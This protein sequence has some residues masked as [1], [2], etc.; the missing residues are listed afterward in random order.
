MASTKMREIKNEY[1]LDLK[2]SESELDS[3]L[4]IDPNAAKSEYDRMLLSQNSETIKS[5]APEIQ[6]YIARNIIKPLE[7]RLEMENLPAPEVKV[8]KIGPAF[9]FHSDE[10]KGTI[11][12]NPLAVLEWIKGTSYDKS[13][14]HEY[15]HFL[16]HLFNRESIA[17][18]VKIN[19]RFDKMYG[20]GLFLKDNLV[21]TEGFAE[22][23]AAKDDEKLM[24][25][26]S[27]AKGYADAKKVSEWEGIRFLRKAFDSPYALGSIIYDLAFRAGGVKEVKKLAFEGVRDYKEMK[28]LYTGYCEK[29]GLEPIVAPR[30]RTT[31]SNTYK[32]MV[33]YNATPK[34]ESLKAALHK[35]D[36][37]MRRQCEAGKDP[38]ILQFCDPSIISDI[39]AESYWNHGTIVSSFSMLDPEKV[40]QENMKGEGMSAVIEELSKG[41]WTIVIDSGEYN[42]QYMKDLC[43]EEG[44]AYFSIR[45]EIPTRL[46][47]KKK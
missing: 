38:K 8:S 28:E 17:N 27:L 5:K 29:L 10:E 21:Q 13:L 34:D 43:R 42:Q 22:W 16:S 6:E 36:E 37:E 39:I 11:Y 15:G 25:Y 9:A 47:D 14:R 23:L 12:A 4:H 3:L 40:R 20:K 19:L 33:A 1:G 35:V 7:E 18:D 45:S 32:D 41:R 44:V 2:L 46:S 24:T 30:R 26:E 31:L